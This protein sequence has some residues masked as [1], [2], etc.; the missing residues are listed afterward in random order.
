MPVNDNDE[1]KLI[2][3]LLGGF[4][5]EDD[6]S[7]IEQ[8]YIHSDAYSDEL[9]RL[10]DRLIGDYLHDKL[11]ERHRLLFE[12]NFLASERRRKRMEIQRGMEVFFSKNREAERLG[13]PDPVALNPTLAVSGH[14]VWAFQAI[15]TAILLG[16][17]L[18]VAVLS[19]RQHTEL[20]DLRLARSRPPGV[21]ASAAS[22]PREFSL[23]SGLQRSAAGV[24]RIALAPGELVAVLRLKLD[25]APRRFR[26]YEATFET[27]E[28]KPIWTQYQIEPLVDGGDEYLKVIVP[29]A[30]LPRGEYVVAV[31]GITDSG[32][33]ETLPSF[34]FLSETSISQQ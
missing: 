3:Y 32:S 20:A 21:E 6:Q 9:Q 4:L 19:W 13:A 27:A 17:F 18:G 1:E 33:R 8:R 11:P 15:A 7:R 16:A 10:E 26:R 14:R 25:S 31:A 30:V 12:K 24:N 28:G 5:S 23:S 22:S 29:A 2:L 34:V